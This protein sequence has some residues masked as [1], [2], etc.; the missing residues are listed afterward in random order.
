M[1][2]KCFDWHG[3]LCHFMTVTDTMES[4]DRN[5]QNEK[6]VQIEDRK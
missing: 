4:P 3:R 5:I 6:G 1:F 2:R